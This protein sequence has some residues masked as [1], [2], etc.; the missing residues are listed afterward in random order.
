[1]L[2][3]L[4]VATAL[5]YPRCAARR[6]G[7]STRSCC[8][9][10]TT[11]RSARPSRAARRTTTTCRRCSTRSCRQLAPAL[12]RARCHLARVAARATSGTITASADRRDR[13][14]GRRDRARPRDRRDRGRACSCR[15]A[16][17]RATRST[18]AALT[19][20]RRLLSDDV[21][22]ARG[23]RRR[24]RRGASTPSGSRTSGT[25][26]ELREQEI[27]K[28]ATEA[29]LRALRAQINPH[30]LFNA[31]TTIGYL[32]QTAPPRALDT[33]LRLTALLRGVLRSEGEFTT[34]GRELE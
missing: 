11:R 31:L 18:I 15:R 30:F 29:E 6:P 7:S 23:D 19:G 14:D 27:G 5:L 12:E 32:I 13:R 9:G 34:L 25:T 21:A 33:L 8:I 16:K 28:L 1:M 10:R 17:R 3:T 4:W 2:V 24:R 20:G 26:R 22:H